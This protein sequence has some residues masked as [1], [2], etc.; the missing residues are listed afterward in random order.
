MP[1]RCHAE[2]DGQGVVLSQIEEMADSE[3]LCAFFLEMGIEA[4]VY[5]RIGPSDHRVFLGGTSMEI[6]GRL[7]AGSNIELVE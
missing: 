4:M 2:H 7:I 5:E 1:L 3:F 6:L